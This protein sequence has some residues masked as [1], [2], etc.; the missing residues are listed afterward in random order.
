MR[1]AE[2]SQPQTQLVLVTPP[3]EAADAFAGALDAA[4]SGG[5]VAAV[6]ARFAAADERTLVNAVKTLAPVVQKHGTALIVE[7][8]PAVV[9]RGGADGCHLAFDMQRLAD[10]VASL[11]PQRMVGVS[12]LKS[13][14]DAMA[15]GEKGADYVMFGEPMVS[16]HAEKNGL[17]PPIHAVVERVGWWAELFEVPVIGF[18]PDIAGAA[19]L[20]AVSADF[21]A[22][23]DPVWNHAVG[24]QAGVAEA[25]AAIAGARRP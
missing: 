10:A 13:R 6:I 21:V 22:L 20:A 15:A 12:G 24:P 3:I 8:S 5:P 19:A 9:A 17:L 1:N 18:A 14:D 16:R 4:L 7:A 11:A 2:P 25:L 23:A